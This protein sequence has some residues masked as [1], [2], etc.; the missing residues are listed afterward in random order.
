[1]R[2]KAQ[3]TLKLIQTPSPQEFVD[4]KRQKLE[5][6]E[7]QVEQLQASVKATSKE[8]LQMEE[9]L[10]RNNEKIQQLSK[11]HSDNKN[12]IVQKL[13]SSTEENQEVSLKKLRERLT[14]LQDQKSQLV[15]EKMDKAKK[16]RETSSCLQ[17]KLA[18]LEN[19][20]SQYVKCQLTEKSEI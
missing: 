6:L 7:R 3:A 4:D 13:S 2:I 8:N 20:F 16:F 10:M 5:M 1:M 14:E 12:L 9:Q 11:Q 15:S 18:N 17:A 19:K